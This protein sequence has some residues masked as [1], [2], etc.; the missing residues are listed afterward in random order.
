[1]AFT[2]RTMRPDE[3]GAV[4]ELICSSMN[5]WDMIHGSPGRFS[6]GPEQTALFPRIYEQLDPGMCLVA[7]A[8]NGALAGCCFHR[9]RDTHVALGIMNVGSNYAG[10][11]VA[12]LMLERVVSFQESTGKPLRL[13]S[14]VMNLDSYSLYN[15]AGF[16]P[17]LLYQD[18]V[19]QVPADGIPNLIA[20]AEHVRPATLDDVE[21]IAELEL[22]LSGISRRKDYRYFI[23][24]ADGF[25][26]TSVIEGHDGRLD[27]Y[28]VSIG[29]PLFRETG[30]GVARSEEQAAAL[31]VTELNHHRGEWV[32]FLVPVECRGIVAL[33]YGWG[34]RNCEMHA[35]QVRGESQPFRGI[36][37]PTFLPE[38]G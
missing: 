8:P 4:A 6:G 21:P 9:E 7:E 18:L 13:V 32:L 15:R 12:K 16:V 35:A 36:S 5:T 37:F 29:H 26:S 27:G 30:P 1:M 34:A 10:Q 31:L 25:W 2:L 28:L 20:G 3:H 22:E 24:N 14:S 11:G 17:R 23:E 38:T 33:A 19:M